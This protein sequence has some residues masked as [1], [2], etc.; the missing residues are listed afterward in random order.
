MGYYIFADYVSGNQWVV[1]PSRTLT[2]QLTDDAAFPANIVAF[3][4]AENG[5]LYA[6]SLSGNAIYK[7]L[8]NAALPV[9]F[10]TINAVRKGTTLHINW[11]TETETNNSHFEIE[12]SVDGKTFTTIKTVDTKAIN[13]NSNST[14]EY[15][16]TLDKNSLGIVLGISLLTLLS[17]A[18]WK[19]GK[20][21]RKISLL[22]TAF[23]IIGSAC[24]KSDVAEEP[25]DS[26]LFIRIAQ[27]DKDGTKRYSQSVQVVN[28]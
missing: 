18:G 12:G 22:A 4:E 19:S 10:G 9:T 13:G 26:T 27:V 14:I 25:G 28:P 6:A 7:V 15:A 20:N 5:T 3:G 1:N 23:F 21:W 24:N 11:T 8:D 2:E 17:I 16:V